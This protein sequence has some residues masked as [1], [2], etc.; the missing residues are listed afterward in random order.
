MV[1]KDVRSEIDAFKDEKIREERQSRAE[2]EYEYS[3]LYAEEQKTWKV[4][5]QNLRRAT[6]VDYVEWLFGYIQNG[7]KPTHYY[8]YELPRRDFYVATQDFEI[9]PLYGSSSVSIIVPKNI[10]FL[11]GELGNNKIYLLKGYE[12]LG[13]WVPVYKDI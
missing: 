13:G 10:N 6:E 9:R 11:G 8:D 1:Y 2:H 4:L 5:K 7:G 12:C 3:K